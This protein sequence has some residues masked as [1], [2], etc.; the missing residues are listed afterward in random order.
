MNDLKQEDRQEDGQEETYDFDTVLSRQGT[1]SMKWDRYDGTEVLPFWVADMDFAVAPPIR[2]ALEARLAHPIYGYTVASDALVEAVTAHLA[3][4]YGWSVEPEWLVWLPGVV[5]GLA[6]SCRAFCGSG[7]EVLVN[8][9]IYHHFLDSHEEARQHLVQVPLRRGE[10]GR[11]TYDVEAMRAAASERTRLLMMCTP[12]NPTGTVFTPEELR[13]VADLCAERDLI[14]VSDEIHCDLVL[15]ET[16]RHV[17]TA[18]ACPERAHRMITLMSASK[19]WNIAGLNCSFAVV[20]DESLRER[21]RVGCRGLV[22]PVPP[23][24]FEAT[25][26]AY[27]EGDAWRR[28]LLDYLRGNLALIGERVA[29]MDGLALEPLQATYLAWIDASGL[30]LDDPQ[31]WFERHGAGLSSGAQFGQPGHLRLNFACPRATLEEG[32][33]RMRRAVLAAAGQARQGGRTG[34]IRAGQIRAG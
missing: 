18:L 11:S 28:Q 9:P 16:V 20:P 10:G 7:E 31:A 4:E 13:S 21:F 23:F 6:A 25:R 2:R 14:M 34:Q 5:P 29:T 24:A 8:P 12:H 26:A 22:P 32:L 30:G 33:D 3:S 17:P 15:D 1:S 19:T 27:A